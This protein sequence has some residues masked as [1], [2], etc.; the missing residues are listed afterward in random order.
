[1]SR[2]DV[3]SSILLPIVKYDINTIPLLTLKT[4]SIIHPAKIYY[5]LFLKVNLYDMVIISKKNL[6]QISIK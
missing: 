6:T 2:T 1:M 4:S 5:I 3:A